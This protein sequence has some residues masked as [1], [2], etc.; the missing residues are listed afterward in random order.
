M[1]SLI[2]D[3]VMT[4]CVASMMAHMRRSLTASIIQCSSEALGLYLREE[5][6]KNRKSSQFWFMKC[7]YFNTEN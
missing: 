3:S 6:T 5:E 4:K 2:K 7:F 1:L